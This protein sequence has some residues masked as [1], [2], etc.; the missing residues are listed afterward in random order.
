MAM[1]WV[2]TGFQAYASAIRAQ[3]AL[4]RAWTW[5]PAVVF[6]LQ[7]L[8]MNFNMGLGTATRV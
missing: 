4:V 5:F 7:Q 1:P 3:S 2:R 8:A 6:S